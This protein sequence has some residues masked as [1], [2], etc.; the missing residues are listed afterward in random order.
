[1]SQ[2]ND[3]IGYTNL[4]GMTTWTEWSTVVSRA[5]EGMMCARRDGSQRRQFNNICFELLLCLLFLSGVLVSSDSHG[6]H[7]TTT[8]IVAELKPILTKRNALSFSNGWH[9]D[10]H[11]QNLTKKKK[12]KGVDRRCFSFRSLFG[13]HISFVGIQV[14]CVSNLFFISSTNIWISRGIRMA[15]V[16]T[17]A[18]TFSGFFSLS[19]SSLYDA[20]FH[21]FSI[22][23]WDYDQHFI[24]IIFIFSI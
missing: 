2:C 20:I 6:A 19:P 14:I 21:R 24:F 8:R 17:R 4:D 9:L 10:F 22:F 16:I 11:T 5:A 13:N 1:M 7:L 23:A 12:K 15:L 18:G 3:Y